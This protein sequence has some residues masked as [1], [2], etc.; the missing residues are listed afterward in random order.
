MGSQEESGAKGKWCSV[1]C[2]SEPC[3]PELNSLLA[4]YRIA[5]ARVVFSI[6]E[7]DIETLFDRGIS[8]PRQL[9]YIEW[10]SVFPATTDPDSLLYKVSRSYARG[11]ERLAEIIPLANI[12]RSIHLLPKFG[13][14]APT[15]WSSSNVLEQCKTYYVNAFTDPHIYRILY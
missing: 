6:L 4:G 11:G 9:V 2:S 8:V 5:Q 7:K 3:Y 14:I 10:F 1:I 13:P 15:A 12:R